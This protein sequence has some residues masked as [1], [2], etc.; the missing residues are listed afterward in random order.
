MVVIIFIIVLWVILD[1]LN[2]KSSNTS[3]YNSQASSY[4]SST[5]NDIDDDDD[6]E[7]EYLQVHTSETGLARKLLNNTGSKRMAKDIL[8]EKYGYS[9]S[10]AKG[11][12]GYK[13][14]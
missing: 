3:S 1:F 12:A 8:V 14:Y 6:E 7:D 2:E 4:K 5:Y 9:Q 13:G 11:L 10:E